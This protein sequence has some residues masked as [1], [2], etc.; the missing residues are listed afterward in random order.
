M[1]F[2]KLSQAGI[3]L[4]M[5]IITAYGSRD[6]FIKK[7][8]LS[9]TLD[10]ILQVRD[11]AIV[12]Y[13]SEVNKVITLHLS[14]LTTSI[15]QYI[16]TNMYRPLKVKELASHFNISESKLRTLFK[17]ELGS[18]VQDYIIERKIEEAKLMLKS[19]VTT[20]EAAYTLGFAD[21]SPLLTSL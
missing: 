7:T 4:G 20:N 8:E 13:T 21:A 12:Y 6:L 9:N 11:S 19:N 15:I 10:E 5:D 17:T 14:P 3:E 1:V 18:T 2:E 16:N